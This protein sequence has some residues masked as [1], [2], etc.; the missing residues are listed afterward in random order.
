MLTVSKTIIQGFFMKLKIKALYDKVYK[1]LS[2]YWARLIKPALEIIGIIII[3]AIIAHVMGGNE[4]LL[5]YA[6]K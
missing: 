4:T 3:C 5:E 2:P 6:Q 1:L